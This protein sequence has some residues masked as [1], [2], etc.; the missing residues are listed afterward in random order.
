MRSYR[1]LSGGAVAVALFTAACVNNQSTPPPDVDGGVTP[2]DAGPGTDG[3]IVAVDA[4]DATAPSDTGTTADAT[5]GFDAA[6]LVC[7]DA[8]GPARNPTFGTAWP[9][10]RAA[11]EFVGSPESA[12]FAKLTPAE[13]R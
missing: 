8:A 6:A 4:G 3:T 10:L 7:T 11:V 1:L 12:A 13:G 2:F 5:P 9:N